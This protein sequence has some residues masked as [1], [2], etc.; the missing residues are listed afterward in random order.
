MNDI[1][2]H[3]GPLVIAHYEKGSSSPK[4]Y[5]MGSN[6]RMLT[7]DENVPTDRVYEITTRSHPRV[8]DDLLDGSEVIGSRFD[9]SKAQGRAEIIGK[10]M[11]DAPV[12]L[13]VVKKRELP[14]YLRVIK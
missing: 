2:E 6:I 11:A 10:V 8:L 9:G 4:F 1:K 7:I 14:S 5:V 13:P 12:P 3:T